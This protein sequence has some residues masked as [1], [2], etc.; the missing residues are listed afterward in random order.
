M[1]VEE[2]LGQMCP[3]SSGKSLGNH[4]LSLSLDMSENIAQAVVDSQIGTT[5]SE[6]GIA[7]R[8]EM[9]K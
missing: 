4:L 1:F 2:F 9:Q 6:A 7:R 3:L 5:R 8:R